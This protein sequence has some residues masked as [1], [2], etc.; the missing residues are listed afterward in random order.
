MNTDLFNYKLRFIS[1]LLVVGY[2]Y[3]HMQIADVYSGADLN[4]L[5]DFKVR[6]PYGQRFLLPAIAHVIRYILPLNT[7]E[8]FF[9][10]ELMFVSLFYFTHLQLLR[11]AFDDKVA[12]VLNWL[13]LLIL[14][15]M[16]VINYR[17]TLYGEANF[18]YV[19]D[20]AALFFIAAGMYLCLRQY[21][22]SFFALILVATLNRESAILLVF[23]IPALY[24]QQFGE[25]IRVFTLAALVYVL[26]RLLVIVLTS[27]LAGTLVE[28]YFRGS[29]YTLFITNLTWLLREYNVLFYV[30]CLSGLPL[31]FFTFHDYI[32]KNYLPVRYLALAYWLGLLCV[33]ITMESRIYHE[34]LVLLY[35]PVCQGV[36]NW[37]THPALVKDKE[38]QASWLYWL[39]RYGVILITF[40]TLLL[41]KPINTLILFL[42]PR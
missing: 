26:T 17:F 35:L 39:N 3:L 38:T 7:S 27:H 6:L 33:G 15:L 23:L 16:S 28:W 9:L 10:L 20:S 11:L 18:F 14:P 25:K 13:F 19:S 40:A 32:P 1:I 22:Y 30:Y 24:W 29:Q 41:Q 4:Q 8:L 37:L 36:A 31:L 34:I 21:W 42:F 2:A 5:I 12:K